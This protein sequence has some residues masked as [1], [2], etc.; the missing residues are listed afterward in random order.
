M[1]PYTTDSRIAIE[2]YDSVSFFDGNASSGKHTYTHINA[3]KTWLFASA[4]NRDRFASYPERYA[5]PIQR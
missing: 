5:P 2:G 1:N 3:G 4:E